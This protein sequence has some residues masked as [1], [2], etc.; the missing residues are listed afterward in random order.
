M[1]PKLCVVDVRLR[2]SSLINLSPSD[3]PYQRCP[4]TPESSK[5]CVET[6]QEETS[7]H[8]YL[9]MLTKP[10]KNT[11]LIQCLHLLSSPVPTS[12]V[13][14]LQS[15]PMTTTEQVA[16]PSSSSFVRNGW[17][18]FLRFTGTI[19]TGLGN[20]NNNNNKVMM[21]P[22]PD[23]TMNTP[24]SGTYI[25]MLAP[26]NSIGSGKQAQLPDWS[27][28]LTSVRALLVDDNPVNQ[29]VLTRM[30]NRL[31]LTCDVAQN[32]REAVEKWITSEQQGIPLQLI[33]MDVFMPEM[34]GLEATTKIRSESSTTATRPYIIAMTACVMAGDRE[35]CIDAGMNGYVSKPVR[36][37]ELE[38]AIHTFT[39][40]AASE[41]KQGDTS[42]D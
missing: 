42:I 10:F 22:I 38:A 17:D 18:S 39:Q 37:E 40:V 30:L 8:F 12:S 31:G 29:K 34:N 25:S 28:K 41:K 4:R 9:Q 20:N 1:I 21:T 32:G 36:K 3:R 33:F 19:N 6:P 23:D 35:K 7:N 11:K 14:L 2:N 13:S 5:L 27:E 26:N 16:N 24:T 15:S